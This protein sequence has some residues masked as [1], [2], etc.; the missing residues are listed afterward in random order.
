M[1]EGRD[2]CG[3]WANTGTWVENRTED[4]HVDIGLPG[5]YVPGQDPII[6]P[7]GGY[8]VNHCVVDVDEVITILPDPPLAGLH[9]L[10]TA[11]GLNPAMVSKV[12]SLDTNAE[13]LRGEKHM[14][15]SIAWTQYTTY[16]ATLL[17]S[18]I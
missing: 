2:G 9:D 10:L 11:R 6:A 4:T 3:V 14:A 17:N 18:M 8:V 7:A 13:F 16:C 12:W 5:G 15:Y 1:P